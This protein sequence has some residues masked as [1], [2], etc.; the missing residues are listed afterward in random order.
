MATTGWR[1]SGTEHPRVDA[2]LGILESGQEWDFELETVADDARVGKMLCVCAA[3]AVARYTVEQAGARADE[4]DV[5]DAWVDAPTEELLASIWKRVLHGRLDRTSDVDDVVWWALRSAT[6]SVGDFEAG[7]AL[8][9]T[10]EAALRRG[11]T[12]GRVKAIVRRALA[13]RRLAS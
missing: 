1:W 2:L 6:A 8:E 10:C 12:A 7:W 13:G 9:M 3:A 4:L 5:L 11:V